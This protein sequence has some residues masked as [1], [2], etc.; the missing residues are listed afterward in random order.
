LKPLAERCEAF[1]PLGWGVN[2]FGKVAVWHGLLLITVEQDPEKYIA[3]VY[4]QGVFERL[5]VVV[6]ECLYDVLKDADTW[7]KENT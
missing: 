4:R 1:W 6:G 3:R 7:V 5:H 2:A